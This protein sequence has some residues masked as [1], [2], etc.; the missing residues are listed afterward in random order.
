MV[1][2]DATAPQRRLGAYF[3]A[4]TQ[5]TTFTVWAPLA[6]R[7]QIRW[8]REPVSIW[9]AESERKAAWLGVQDLQSSSGG[10]WWLETDQA[11]PGTLYTYVLDEQTERPDPCSRAQPGGV[12]GASQVINHRFAWHDQSWQGRDWREL[13]FYELHVGTFSQ[14]GTFAE[15]IA[16][17]PRLAELGITAIELMPVAQFSGTRNWGYDGVYLYAVQQNYGGANGLKALVDAAHQFGIAVY[18]DVVYNHLGPEG[19]YLDQFGPYFRKSKSTPWG[20]AINF[21]GRNSSEVR[22]FFLDNALEWLRDYHLDGL[23]LDA[24][25]AYHDQSS[26]SFLQELSAAVEKLSQELQRPLYLIGESNLNDWRL[27][28]PIAQGGQGLHGQWNEDYQRAWQAYL[29]GE[30]A[31]SYAD[32]GE[33]AQ[34]RTVAEQAFYLTG[35]P[36]QYRYQPHGQPLPWDAALR[37][38]LIEQ[39]IVYLQNHDQIG[40]RPGGER[41]TTLIPFEQYQVALGLLCLGPSV[42]LLFMGEEYYEQA[43]FYYVVD[44][45]FPGLNESIRRGRESYFA[46]CDWTAGQ[47]ADPALL[48]TFLRSKLDVSQME[49]N[50]TS[51]LWS[52]Y[53]KQLLRIRQR[54]FTP[55]A[56]AAIEWKLL[57]ATSVAT[58]C[59]WYQSCQGQFLV[60]A[61]CA[62][63]PVQQTVNEVPIN[64][65]RCVLASSSMEYGDDQQAAQQTNS[66]KH[67]ELMG[68]NLQVWE[69]E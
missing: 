42:P 51:R 67:F 8:H 2:H 66:L 48:T 38:N 62:A 27:T 13:V 22:R 26:P 32:F 1:N 65:R 15:V 44:H 34:C 43:P 46:T 68:W 12:H 50:H 63:T 20:A 17:L 24:I 47:I 9:N 60:L 29:T 4:L 14:P 39:S 19:N 23:R 41:L 37:K 49:H 54:L 45:A 36:S 28:Q 52:E 3:D 11:P 69:I 61:N 18:L 33:F 5:R 53:V 55:G 7:V 25:H 21:A 59:Y 10:Y 16:Q 31:G 40:N 35:Q 30:R 57:S 58:I 56:T 6:K 64:S